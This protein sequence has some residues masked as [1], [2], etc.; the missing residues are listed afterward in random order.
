MMEEHLYTIKE[1]MKI[2]S[3]S[4]ATIYRLMYAGKLPRV[5][6]GKSVRIP[7]SAVEAVIRANTEEIMIKE[8]ADEE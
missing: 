5:K 6:I 3:V 8:K 4:Q 2:L 7:A 1:V